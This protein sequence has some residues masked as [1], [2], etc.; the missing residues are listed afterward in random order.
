MALLIPQLLFQGF[1][2]N[3]G[4][5]SGGLLYTYAAGT[6]VPAIVYQDPGLGSAWAN[7]VPLNALG[8]ALIY[9]NPG[10]AYKF[11]LTDSQGNQIPGYPV[12][13]VNSNLSF[14]AVSSNI[15]PSVND[16]YTL[17]APGF[18]WAQV[19]VEG[20]G[21]YDP[22]TGNVGYYGQTAAEKAASV[23]PT[24][25]VYAAGN[26][27]RYGA[28]GNGTADDTAAIQKAINAGSSPLST[29]DAG[30]VY[31]PPGNFKISSVLTCSLA[32]GLTILGAGPGATTITMA[33]ATQT[34]ISI[35]NTSQVSP[36]ITVENLTIVGAATMTGGSC[37][38]VMNAG[39]IHVNNVVFGGNGFSINIGLTLDAATPAGVG[40]FS[41]Y[42]K[43]C[44][45][46][47]CA[48][49]IVIGPTSFV[50]DV[51]IRDTVIFGATTAG[52]TFISASGCYL[53]AVSTASCATGILTNPGASQSVNAI[54]FDKCLADTGSGH[55][56]NIT[57]NGGYVVELMLSDCWGCGAGNVVGGSTTANGVNIAQGTGVINGLVIRGGIFHHNYGAGI[58]IGASTNVA[59]TGG[60]QVYQNSFVG[61]SD[62]SGIEIA[63]NV[64]QFSITDNICGSGGY[65]GAEVGL[66]NNQAYGIY[67]LAGTSNNYTI[68]GNNCVGN[69]LSGVGDSG[70]GASKTV[71]GNAGYNPLANA[72]ITVGGSPFT[73][74]NDVGAPIEVFIS[75][76]TVGSVV[77]NG[78]TLATS[79]NCAVILPQAGFVVVTWSGKPTMTFS[80]LA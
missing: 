27:F 72:S 43:D 60:A 45:I 58:L 4:F 23:T 15:V 37:I 66:A 11:N 34:G 61:G 17:G 36:N 21:I 19:Y 20:V 46:N 80:G 71:T 40:G 47:A 74:T 29:A 10:Q 79:T 16:L 52:V 38:S 14:P 2:P 54:F 35:G 8:Q 65:F 1:S 57:T 76:G 67:V 18:S 39:N 50:E 25:Y 42:V 5:L 33:T 62:R 68:T 64:N 26:V 13:Q 70:S 22:T 3:G 69:A 6:S 49:G 41:Y 30:I 59:V 9:L 12:D 32:G 48:Q 44:E 53:S 75:A 56:W 63:A 51:F 78:V 28:L 7:P 24:N 77:V 73:F 55:S 31:L